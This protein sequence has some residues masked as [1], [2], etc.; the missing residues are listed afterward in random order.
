LWFTKPVESVPERTKNA[1]YHISKGLEPLF[2]DGISI[3]D[4]SHSSPAFGKS[5]I[6]VMGSAPMLTPV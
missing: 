4:F 1:E 5:T 3:G 2:S 6:L